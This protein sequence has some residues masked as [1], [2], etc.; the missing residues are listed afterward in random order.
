MKAAGHTVAVVPPL[1]CGE[2]IAL[3]LHYA[4][5]PPLHSRYTL[6]VRRYVAASQPLPPATFC[7]CYTAACAAVQ[8][9]NSCEAAVAEWPLRGRCGAA[10]ERG[11]GAAA[12]LLR[13]GYGA[14]VSARGDEDGP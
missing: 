13:S 12:E 14:A 10:A 6:A 11:C 4:T 8:L 3:P 2:L 5:A 1:L 9:C 7:C